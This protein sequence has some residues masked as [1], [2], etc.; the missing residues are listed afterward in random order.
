[1]PK[2]ALS[3]TGDISACEKLRP[4]FCDGRV[5]LLR[6]CNAQ[7]C[8]QAV[9]IDADV[10]IGLDK[11]PLPHIACANV[12]YETLSLL[13]LAQCGYVTFPMIQR[14]GLL[15]FAKAAPW[16]NSIEL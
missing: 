16:L 12:C 5:Q 15:R 6:A 3:Q 2:G 14:I 9:F 13:N 1:M 8:K 11:R 4:P 10:K 7:A